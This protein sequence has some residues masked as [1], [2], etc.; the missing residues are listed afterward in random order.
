MDE[1][2]QYTT[3]C[4]APLSRWGRCIWWFFFSSRRRHTRWPRDWSSDVCSSDLV[5]Q[6][7][8]GVPGQ[9]RVHV[10][11]LG[12]GELRCPLLELLPG[13]GGAIGEPGG[14]E[15]VLV[16]VEQRGGATVGQG[17]LLIG[18]LVVLHERV[19]VVGQVDVELLDEG[20]EGDDVAVDVVAEPPHV[21]RKST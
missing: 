16:V 10:G 3:A 19:A 6:G 8:A 1:L 12:L 18:V 13:L 15:V 21:D 9:V 14:G 11:D 20:V 2:A 5:L 4:L 17:P 7:P